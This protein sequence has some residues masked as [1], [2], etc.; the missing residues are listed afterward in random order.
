MWQFFISNLKQTNKNMVVKMNTFGHSIGIRIYDQLSW[1]LFFI[2]L[3]GDLKESY[4][5]LWDIF[6]IFRKHINHCKVTKMDPDLYD[7]FGNYVG[8]DLESEEDSSEEERE[9]RDE[10]ERMDDEEDQ[11]SYT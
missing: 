2:R 6:H 11:V 3:P 7:E 9:D 5:S 10:E 8:P 4:E 1:F